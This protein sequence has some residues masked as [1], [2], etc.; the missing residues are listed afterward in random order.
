MWPLRWNHW[1]ALNT[2]PGRVG[3]GWAKVRGLVSWPSMPAPGRAVNM[4]AAGHR[5]SKGGSGSAGRQLSLLLSRVA[6][7][8]G[9]P[10][11][12]VTRAWS[13]WSLPSC[14]PVE[15]CA[16]APWMGL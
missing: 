6:L 13:F 11:P 15:G 8:Q 12:G 4:G 14:L 7:L 10:W 2:G 9:R 1:K 3:D 16:N 5:G